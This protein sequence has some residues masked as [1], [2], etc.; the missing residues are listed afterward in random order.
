M[1]LNQLFSLTRRSFQTIQAA[2][3]TVGQN[4]ANANTEGYARR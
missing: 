2:M 3:N 1:S 4:V